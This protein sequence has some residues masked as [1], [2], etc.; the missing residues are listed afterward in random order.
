MGSTMEVP[1]YSRL[2]MEIAFAF[3]VGLTV[4]PLVLDPLIGRVRR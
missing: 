4:G 1:V 2:L 3:V